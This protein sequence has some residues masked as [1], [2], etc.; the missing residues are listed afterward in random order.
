MLTWSQLCRIIIQKNVEHL[1]PSKDTSV[2]MTVLLI[3]N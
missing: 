1:C 3:K 2:K